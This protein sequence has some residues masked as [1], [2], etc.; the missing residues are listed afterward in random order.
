MSS[1]E[2]AVT[3]LE[4]VVRVLIV[5]DSAYVRKVVRQMLLRSRSI[6]VVGAARDGNEALELVE[7]LEPD[8]VV[9]DLIMPNLDGVQFLRAQ[10]ARRAVAVVVLS[11]ASESG[12]NVLA[13]LDAGAIDFIQ[14]PTALAT[15]KIYEIGD[16]L[17]RK[18]RA[19]AA[20]PL[21]RLQRGHP[22]PGPS[23]EAS[24]PI[25]RAGLTDIVVIGVSTGGPQALS[26]IIP[27]LPADFPVPVAMVIHMPIGYTALF[28]RRLAES[29]RLRV[30]EARQGDP[31]AAGT[32]LVAP[33]GRHLSFRRGSRG[34][35]SVHLD[36]RPA[37]T[38]H[39]P[40]VDVLFQSAA[41]I[42]GSRV[43]G[44]VLSGMGSDGTEG[45]RRIKAQGGRILTES[46]RTCVVYGMPRSVV[47]AGL[48][49]RSEPL[50]A[51]A[52][53]IQ[54]MS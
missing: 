9:T 33:A 53:S 21:A 14:K 8:V 39:R 28:A 32:A 4:R 47:E 43:L 3:S 48:S 42:Y 40:A 25:P 31:V 23:V 30:M 19:A 10:M 34:D 45:A 18:V 49:D 44:V 41:D 12:E 13:A 17:V 54:E 52:R 36:V 15:D 27:Q 1:T 16:E 7:R 37:D 46:E 22:A 2:A 6:E 26:A 35:V 20:A 38:P 50:E 29:S 11:I 51:V 24:A 5:D